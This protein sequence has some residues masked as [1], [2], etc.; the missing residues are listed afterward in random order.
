VQ[1]GVNAK[2]YEK[3]LSAKECSIDEVWDIVCGGF[4]S[5]EEISANYKPWGE[6]GNRNYTKK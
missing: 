3:Q 5:I 6:Y 2:S 4:D 1:K